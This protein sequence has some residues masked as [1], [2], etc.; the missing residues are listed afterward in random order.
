MNVN[1]LLNMAGGP[2]GIARLGQQFGL[3]PQQT[4]AAAEQLMPA[5]MGGFKKQAQSGGGLE[6]L[7]GAVTRVGASPQPGSGETPDI[8]NAVLGQIFGSKDVSR[9]VAAQAAQSS[10]I[11]G[12]VL[13]KLLPVLAAAAAGGLLK[14][15]AAPAGGGGG[16]LGQLLGGLMGRKQAAPQAGIGGLASMLDLDGDGNPLDDIM[17]MAGKMMGR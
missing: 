12:D 13:K 1:D 14:G 15:G 10:G 5:I 16:L 6:S 7:L 8:G 11:S 2:A 4:Q 3:S 17:G 9:T